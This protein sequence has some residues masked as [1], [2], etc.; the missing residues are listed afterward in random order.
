LPGVI[1]NVLLDVN[2]KGVYATITSSEGV[3]YGFLIH[4]TAGKGLDE[5][6]LFKIFTLSNKAELFECAPSIIIDGVKFKSSNRQQMI[7]MLNITAKANDS[8]VTDANCVAQLVKYT[9]N[10]DGKLMYIDTAS[11]D[12]TGTLGAYDDAIGDNS[13]YRN[14]IAENT[15]YRTNSN[16]FMGVG[17]INGAT[18]PVFLHP[19]LGSADYLDE[20]NYEIRTN[21]FTT[22][23][24]YKNVKLYYDKQQSVTSTAVTM[25]TKI[26]SD[27]IAEKTQFC[28]FVRS[29]QVETDD[30]LVLSNL[31]FYVDGSL[32]TKVCAPNV[33][34][35]YYSEQA[36]AMNV[37]DLKKGDV[38]RYNL[39][40]KG[41]IC[42]IEMIY[43]PTTDG[44]TLEYPGKIYS[45]TTSNDFYTSFRVR[46][47]R[48]I[49]NFDDGIVVKTLDGGIS[50]DTV[51][52]IEIVTKTGT[53]MIYEMKANG[54]QIVKPATFED[55]KALE[56]TDDPS[57]VMVHQWWG[58]TQS[59]YI[60]KQ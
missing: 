39:D 48:V 47:F 19:I 31:Y 36:L 54:D 18:T 44:A 60:I 26:G 33:A 59:A 22:D 8:A 35:K 51:N 27:I 1:I 21:Y 55:F 12:A 15:K 38:F 9:L 32:Q 46:M 2:G 30:D 17:M 4:A 29:T 16:S 42:K 53:V 28:Y 11:K 45:P 5:S 40:N 3:K 50:Y 52:G 43:S 13:L 6:P 34:F 23:I 10:S 57:I 25:A 56:T 14:V 7:T 58:V 41:R 49:N 20:E 24:A 37:S